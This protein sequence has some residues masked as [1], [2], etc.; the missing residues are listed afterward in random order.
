MWSSHV[1]SESINVDAPFG[2]IVTTWTYRL[3]YQCKTKYYPFRERMKH[4]KLYQQQNYAIINHVKMNR[5]TQSTRNKG[6]KKYNNKQQC[7]SPNMY[8]AR[9]INKCNVRVK[10]HLSEVERSIHNAIATA[11]KEN[12]QLYHKYQKCMKFVVNQW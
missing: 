1:H 11:V 12:D 10:S 2:K 5:Q 3:V 6:N 4:W 7:A 9:S 8:L